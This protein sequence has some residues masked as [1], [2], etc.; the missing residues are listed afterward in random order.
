MNLQISEH[1]LPPAVVSSAGITSVL[2][3][4]SLPFTPQKALAAVYISVGQTL[5]HIKLNG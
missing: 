1:V 4:V 3:N 2:G 5:T